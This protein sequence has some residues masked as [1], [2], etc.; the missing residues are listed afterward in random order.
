[1]NNGNSFEWGQRAIKYTETTAG[2]VQQLPPKVSS[3]PWPLDAGTV[4]FRRYPLLPAGTPEQ[5]EQWW[6][7]TH[8]AEESNSSGKRATRVLGEVAGSDAGQSDIREPERDAEHI[9]AEC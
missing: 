1:M 4:I 5:L 6:R 2:A 7:E 9:A 3:P 8:G